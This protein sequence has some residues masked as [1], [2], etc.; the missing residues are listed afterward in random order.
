MSL[1]NELVLPMVPAA[2]MTKALY[3]AGSSVSSAPV[4]VASVGEAN[5]RKSK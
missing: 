5:C 3:F 4:G 1:N 2:E